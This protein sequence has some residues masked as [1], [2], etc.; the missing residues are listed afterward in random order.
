MEYSISFLSTSLATDRDQYIFHI[1]IICYNT[2]HYGKKVHSD[3]VDKSG[4]KQLAYLGLRPQQLIGVVLDLG[5]GRSEKL[6]DTPGL[7]KSCQIIALSRNIFSGYDP[8]IRTLRKKPCGDRRTVEADALAL[9]FGNGSFDYLV[10]VDAI[11]HFLTSR[12]EIKTSFQEVHR[13]LK[14]GEEARFF[15]ANRNDEISAGE[16]FDKGAE[17]KFEQVDP[18]TLER[19]GYFHNTQRLIIIKLLLAEYQFRNIL[20]G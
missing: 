18:D 3:A 6:K 9:P 8:F 14:Q 5:S 10:S 16:V 17:V 13:V 20:I 1:L 7:P 12:G 15:P 4:E 2:A 11:P 19:Y